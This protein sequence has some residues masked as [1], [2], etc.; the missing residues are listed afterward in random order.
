MQW[1]LKRSVVAAAM[2]TSLL[3]ATLASAQIM[4]LAG[5]LSVR[6]VGT[7]EPFD[8]KKEGDI[9]TLTV[10]VEDQKWLFHVTRVDTTTGTDPGMMLLSHLFPPQLHFSGP[11][12]RLE[13]LNRPANKG[14]QFTLE[15]WLYIADNM[16][17]IAAVRTDTKP[18]G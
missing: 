18:A 17:H 8:E 10:F 1:T 4:G 2:V 13:V 15:G 7:F 16:F 12:H 5:P 6:F 11:P 3:G 14:K 9:N